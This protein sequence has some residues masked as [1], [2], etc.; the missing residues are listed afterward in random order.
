MRRWPS[1]ARPSDRAGRPIQARRWLNHRI[2]TF[3][4]RRL[5]PRMQKHPL[6]GAV[7]RS[8]LSAIA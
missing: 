8:L 1:G 6:N 5:N 4:M 2:V 7:S 3:G